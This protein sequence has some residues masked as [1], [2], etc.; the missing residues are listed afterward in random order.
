MGEAKTDI[1]VMKFG[2]TSVSRR[3]SAPVT[4]ARTVPDDARESLA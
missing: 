3:N 4:D 1:V 2:G